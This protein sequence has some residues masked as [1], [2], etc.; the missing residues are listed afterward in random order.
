[1]S[2]AL[3]EL[4]Y[5]RVDAI[6]YAI[7]VG[8]IQAFEIEMTGLTADAFEVDVMRGSRA[9]APLPRLPD[10]PRMFETGDERLAARASVLKRIARLLEHQ[11][12]A[13]C[14]PCRIRARSRVDRAV[15]VDVDHERRR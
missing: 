10:I 5:E 6:E 4:L 15:A 3:F 12:D 14:I 13:I 8:L 1:M 2:T 9:F 7:T 11:E